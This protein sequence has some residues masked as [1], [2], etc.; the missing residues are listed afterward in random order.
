MIFYEKSTKLI[1]NPQNSWKIPEILLKQRGVLLTLL[2]VGAGGLEDVGPE[3]VAQ[4][5][6]DRQVD[7]TKQTSIISKDIT[8]QNFAKNRKFRDWLVIQGDPLNMSVFFW[9]LKMIYLCSVTVY[10][11]EHLKSHILQC[12]RNTA[13]LNWSPCREKVFSCLLMSMRNWTRSW[14]YRYQIPRYV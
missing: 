3:L 12:I 14:V 5:Q 11:R 4:A 13:M 1:E 7:R 10:V 8:G 2:V 9:Y 6:V